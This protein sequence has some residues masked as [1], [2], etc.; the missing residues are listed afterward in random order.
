MHIHPLFIHQ[1]LN[2]VHVT[3]AYENLDRQYENPLL[4]AT[5]V[6]NYAHLDAIPVDKTRALCTVGCLSSV[7]RGGV[8]HSPLFWPFNG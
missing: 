4:G 3:E 8:I 7:C 6:E 2:F 5:M 1:C